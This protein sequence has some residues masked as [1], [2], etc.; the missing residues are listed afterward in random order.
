MILPQTQL[1]ILL[2]AIL[3]VV[4]LGLWASAYK[5]GSKWRFE[6]FYVDFA[7]GAFIAVLIYAFTVGNFGFDGFSVMDDISRASKRSWVFAVAA[8][9][10]FN[11]GNL[12]LTAALSIA[13]MSVAFPIAVGIGVLGG[14]IY[15]SVSRGGAN[16]TELLA[17][18]LIIV[19]TVIVAIIAYLRV[20]ELRNAPPPPSD[21]RKRR[22]PKPFASKGPLMAVLGG[23]FLGISIPLVG[24]ARQPE[25]G[26]GPYSLSVFFTLGLLLSTGLFDLF[27]MNLPVEGEPLEVLDIL[28]VHPLLHLLGMGGGALWATGMVA[29]FVVQ[30]LPPE[31]RAPFY[32]IYGIAPAAALLATLIG[33]VI[34]KEFRGGDGRTKALAWS[35]AGLFVVGAVLLGLS[36]AG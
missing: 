6:L 22:R 11:L 17:G 2:V 21:P 33:L 1:A 30:D 26:L 13:G 27:F 25:I 19:L 8:G 12:F 23:V 4:G 24:L 7:V 36:Q 28:K 35:T 32:V 9:V 16:L 31:Q 15:R 18:S 10:V 14:V 29:T 20:F 34:W 3:A 5:L